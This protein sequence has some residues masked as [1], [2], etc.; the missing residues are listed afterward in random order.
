[1]YACLRRLSVYDVDEWLDF[2]VRPTDVSRLEFA[3]R[4]FRLKTSSFSSPD[5]PRAEASARREAQ[6]GRTGFDPSLRE[7]ARHRPRA[8]SLR[9]P[10]STFR[11]WSAPRHAGR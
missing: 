6:R 9:P 3:R 5:N 11:P 10:A 2:S 8:I 1:M 7:L 4:A